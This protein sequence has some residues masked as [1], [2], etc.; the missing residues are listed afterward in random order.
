MDVR[1]EDECIYK[2]E[3]CINRFDCIDGNFLCSGLVCLSGG[4]RSR[5]A[6]L[7]R[8]EPLPELCTV[9]RDADSNDRD[10][11]HLKKSSFSAGS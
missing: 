9:C 8:F 4:L 10:F 3:D 6:V 11:F 5:G 1:R 7:A 2:N